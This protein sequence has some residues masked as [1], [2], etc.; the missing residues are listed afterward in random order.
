MS[1]FKHLGIKKGTSTWAVP[2]Y[3]NKAE[4][5]SHFLHVIIGG[6]QGYVPLCETSDSRATAGRAKEHTGD[7]YAIA[8]SGTPAYKKVTYS[9]PGSFTFTIPAGVTKLRVEVAGAGG[10]SA[11]GKD[12]WSGDAKDYFRGGK[13][14]NGAKINTTISVTPK[15]NI[16]VTVGKGG[17]APAFGNAG[18]TGGNSSVP[19]VTAG[20][21]AGGAVSKRYGSNGADGANAGNGAGGAGGAYS[22]AAEGGKAGSNGW[23]VIE[24]GQ[25]VQ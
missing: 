1:I 13:G 3:D 11:G 2:I 5:G 18:V 21:G 17:S 10:S 25:G 4:A 7:L 9:T 23:V 6:T 8:T 16:N 12:Y 24:Y 22:G 15:T 20:G 19:G 14:G